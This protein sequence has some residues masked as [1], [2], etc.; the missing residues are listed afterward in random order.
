M[1]GG[2]IMTLSTLDIQRKKFSKTRKTESVLTGSGCYLVIQGY[3]K[4][5]LLRMRYPFNRS[6]QQVDVQLGNWDEDFNTVEDV[7]SES[8]IIK[9]WSRENNRDPRDYKNRNQVK[10]QEKTLQECF[11]SFME[12]HKQ[13]SKE[14]TWVVSQNRL[15]QMLNYFGKDR[16]LSDFLL[17]NGG[18][19]LVIEMMKPIIKRGS[20]EQSGRCRRLLGQV[21]DHCEDIGWMEYG[22][23]P[24]SRKTKLETLNRQKKS[25]KTLSWK[26]VPEFLKTVSEN[27]CDGIKLTD[28]S[29]KFY[30]MSGLRV[31]CCVQLKWDWYDKKKNLITI[32]SETHGL[33]RKKGKGLD[34]LLP[35]S[36]SMKKI[37][38]ELYQMNKHSEYIFWSPNGKKTPHMSRETINKHIRKLGYK[39]RLVSHGW[40]DVVVTSGQEEL[41]TDKDIILRFIGHTEHKQG[42]SGHYD[43]TEFLPERQKFVEDWSELL[44]NN[45]LK[46]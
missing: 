4:R 43:N 37:L 9:K 16:P 5:F 6:G 2:E 41:R 3:S 11:E 1:E 35:V 18:R 10:T 46:I 17:S 28:L 39:G 34:H 23:N 33:K 31:G 29:T 15:N 26:E 44:V 32:P 19:Q 30:L 14:V 12:I 24:S 27:P 38:N 42:T 20:I 45:G 21:F 40:R 8:R 36:R 13:E 7:I 22:Q 25:S